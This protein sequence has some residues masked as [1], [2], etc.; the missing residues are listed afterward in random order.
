MIKLLALYKKPEDEASFLRHYNEVHI[1]IVKTIPGLEKTV[2]NKVVASPMG[3][4]PDYFLI[5]E[6][7]FLDQETFDAA[8]ASPENR[9]AGKDLM[10]F[11]KGLVTL[12]VAQQ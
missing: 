8:M 2:I 10:N 9:A 12:L 11:A 6:M 1:P 3:G 7:H 4:E 5:A